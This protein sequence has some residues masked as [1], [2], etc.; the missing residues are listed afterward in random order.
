MPSNITLLELMRYLRFNLKTGRRRNLLHDKFALD[1]QLW[2]SFIENVRKV[3][4]LSKYNITMDE[5]L[6]PSKARSKFIEYM[7]NKPDKFGL[8]FWLVADV[9]NKYFFD[10][11]SYVGKDDTQSSDVSVPADVVMKLMG[12]IFQLGCLLRVIIFSPHL[13]WNCD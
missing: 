1:S 7:A 5:Q 8:K 2:N 13:T 3:F 10:G 12:P 6:L 11:F 9:E 4:F